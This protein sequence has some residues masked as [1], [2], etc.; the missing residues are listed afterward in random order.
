M[1]AVTAILSCVIKIRGLFKST[2][3]RHLENV[4]FEALSAW[5]DANGRFDWLI[6]G[7]QSVNPSREV[8]SILSD[9]YKRFTFAH[10]VTL[11]NNKAEKWTQLVIFTDMFYSSLFSLGYTEKSRIINFVFLYPSL[12]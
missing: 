10:P 7:H 6:S 3:W 11:L 8:I 12:F 9:K 1:F 4:K 2:K 5:R